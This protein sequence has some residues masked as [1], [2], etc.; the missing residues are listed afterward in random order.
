MWHWNAPI[1]T[2][3]VYKD[4]TDFSLANAVTDADIAHLNRYELQ[5]LRKDGT[6]SAECI[7]LIE[8]IDAAA[9]A[10]SGDHYRKQATAGS[11]GVH[12]A[13]KPINGCGI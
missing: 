12:L 7:A 10:S 6:I 5:Q 13:A 11:G 9:E 4:E 1:G 2:A 8:D 3:S